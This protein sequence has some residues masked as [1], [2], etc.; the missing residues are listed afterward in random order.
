MQAQASFHLVADGLGVPFG[1]PLPEALMAG[2]T[3]SS[4]APLS[5]VGKR[6]RPDVDKYERRLA[7][8]A[9]ADVV[10][11]TVDATMLELS[12]AGYG[13]QLTGSA[14]L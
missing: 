7:A 6:C 14:L 11:Y 9:L 3:R 5:A 2:V 12:I 13:L 1:G 4:F 10:G 8:V